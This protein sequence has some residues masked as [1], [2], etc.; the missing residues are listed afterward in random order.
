MGTRGIQYRDRNEKK[1]RSID[2]YQHLESN[3]Q[4][5]NIHKIRHNGERIWDA[6]FTPLQRMNIV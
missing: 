5:K 4:V 1:E 6:L 3:I 2:N